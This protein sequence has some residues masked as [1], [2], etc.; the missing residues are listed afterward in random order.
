MTATPRYFTGRVIREAKE[1]DFEYASMDDAS[2]F[3]TVF[4]R[5][6][7]SG[8]IKRK[9]LTDYRVAVVGVDDATYRD[10][11]ERGALVTRDGKKITDA[12]CRQPCGDARTWC[13]L[14]EKTAASTRS[15]Q[16]LV[17]ARTRPCWPARRSP[18]GLRRLTSRCHR[19]LTPA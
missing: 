19:S 10:W 13:H 11:A 15:V 2:K 7:F 8:A 5:L 12:R 18:F 1:A 4:H 3:G 17:P 14:R 9:L 16:L 6:G